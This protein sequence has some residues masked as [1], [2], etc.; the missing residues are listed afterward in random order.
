MIFV[1]TNRSFCISFLSSSS[2]LDQEAHFLNRNVILSYMLWL[3]VTRTAKL[4]PHLWYRPQDIIY[5]PA[6]ILFGYYFAVMKLYALCTLHEVRLEYLILSFPCSSSAFLAVRLNRLLG[7]LALA[8]VTSQP[9]RLQWTSKQQL[10][11]VYRPLV[12]EPIRPRVN[13]STLLHRLYH[14]L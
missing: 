6:F 5:V 1:A 9:L 8:L 12:L 11:P 2:Y 7:V 3:T 14:C 10:G 13:A 4:L